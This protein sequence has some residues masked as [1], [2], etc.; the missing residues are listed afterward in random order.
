MWVRLRSFRESTWCEEG[1]GPRDSPG[2]H[3]HLRSEWRSELHYRLE[4]R[5][6][7]SR[8]RKAKVF[9]EETRNTYSFITNAIAWPCPLEIKYIP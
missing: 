1:K 6:Q 8:R 7:G 4:R 3:W 9:Q 2:R 5:G